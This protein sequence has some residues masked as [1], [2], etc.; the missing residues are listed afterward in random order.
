MGRRD[1]HSGVGV[2]MG[3]VARMERRRLPACNPGSADPLVATARSPPDYAAQER[4]SIRATGLGYGRASG[5]FVRS[6]AG[7]CSEAAGRG[8]SLPVTRSGAM[9]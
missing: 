2:A 6:L 8:V 4:C 5:D 7:H 3:C 1:R 9:A